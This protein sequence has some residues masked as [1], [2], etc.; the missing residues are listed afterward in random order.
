MIALLPFPKEGKGQEVKTK[1][2]LSSIVRLFFFGSSSPK[3]K[4]E[5]YFDSSAHGKSA[6]H[7]SDSTQKLE[8]RRPCCWHLFMALEAKTFN[9]SRASGQKVH[10]IR[11]Q[12]LLRAL[13][14][15]LHARSVTV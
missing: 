11:S 12:L 15:A 9:P 10:S 6:P 5:L 4:V 14:F 13:R 7:W 3:N 2:Y 8:T 1:M